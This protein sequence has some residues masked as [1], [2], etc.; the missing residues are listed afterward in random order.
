MNETIKSLGVIEMTPIFTEILKKSVG[1]EMKFLSKLYLMLN[2]H[3][4]IDTSKVNGNEVYIIFCKD[5][6]NEQKGWK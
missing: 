1:N 2:N 5:I 6:G 4:D 3:T